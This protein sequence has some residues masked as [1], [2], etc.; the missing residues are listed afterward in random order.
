MG[1]WGVVTISPCKDVSV[2][3]VAKKHFALLL[4][5]GDDDGAQMHN[6]NTSFC[7]P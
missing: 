1:R 4:L 5:L 6:Q 7:Q 3:S 2:F